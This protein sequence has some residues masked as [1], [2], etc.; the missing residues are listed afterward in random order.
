MS[1]SPRDRI[2][3]GLHLAWISSVILFYWIKRWP[4]MAP[5]VFWPTPGPQFQPLGAVL[6]VG[7]ALAV[8]VVLF[9]RAHRGVPLIFAVL[10]WGTFTVLGF[11]ALAP[12]ISYD[13]LVYHLGLP[14]LWLAADRL[15]STPH[16]IFS[17]TPLGMELLNTGMLALSGEV[18]AKL[19]HASFG[20]LSAVVLCRY[21]SLEA[22][23][24]GALVFLSSPMV[25]LEHVRAANDLPASFLTLCAVVAFTRPPEQANLWHR[26]VLPG[27]IDGL[28]MGFKYTVW[29]LP[30]AMAVAVFCRSSSWRKSLGEA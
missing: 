12:E 14:R 3:D 20:V 21:F 11:H 23:L 22:G 10:A 7:S 18:G 17:G 9:R 4:S 24:A 16:V 19:L 8:G 15:L 25:A 13:A 26:A 2:I 6:I 27:L 30:I 29:A 28:A 1:R 5:G